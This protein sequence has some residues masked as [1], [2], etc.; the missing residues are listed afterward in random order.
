VGQDGESKQV[1]WV[2]REWKYFLVKGLDR[3]NHIDSAQQIARFTHR[4]ASPRSL[5]SGVFAADGPLNRWF[6][7]SVHPVR[8]A[9]FLTQRGMLMQ[10]L[11]ATVVAILILYVADQFLFDGRYFVVAIATLKHVASAVGIPV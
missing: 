11:G 7:G 6:T 5:S 9:I 4:M 1:I 8:P 3:P 2:G 10:A